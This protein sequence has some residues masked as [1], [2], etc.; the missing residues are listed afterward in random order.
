[1]LKFNVA[2]AMTAGFFKAQAKDKSPAVGFDPTSS[3]YRL[4]AISPRA[5]SAP[6]Q[7]RFAQVP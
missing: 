7:I 5:S 3:G 2:C 6:H 1:M 4:R